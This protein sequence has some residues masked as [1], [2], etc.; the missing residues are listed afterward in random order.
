MYSMPVCKHSFI[1]FCCEVKWMEING[2][3]TYHQGQILKEIWRGK[4]RE[5]I[6]ESI[7]T[8][9]RDIYLCKFAAINNF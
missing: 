2:K 5:F 3:N 7:L 6:S 8:Q 1:V 9:I 4:E